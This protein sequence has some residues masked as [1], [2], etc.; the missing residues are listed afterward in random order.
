MAEFTRESIMQG[1]QNQDASMETPESFAT[2]DGA[3]QTRPTRDMS[4]QN[5]RM[6]GQVGARALS[7]MTN[8]DEVA[9]TAEW[10]AKFENNAPQAAEWKMAK[11]NSMAPPP[12]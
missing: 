12:M 4:I 9:R 8:P 1:R 5:Q 10:M 3:A 11:M 7:L 6:A 2:I